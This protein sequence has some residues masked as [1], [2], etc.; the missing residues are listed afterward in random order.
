[1]VETGYFRMTGNSSNPF[2]WRKIQGR[3]VQT[4]PCG[5]ELMFYLIGVFAYKCVHIKNLEKFPK[6]FVVFE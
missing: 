4:H 3:N 2:H 1:M 6:A 5:M